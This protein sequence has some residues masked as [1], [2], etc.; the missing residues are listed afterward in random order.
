M[1]LQVADKHGTRSMAGD[2]P[3]AEPQGMSQARVAAY[4]HDN[5]IARI[6]ARGEHRSAG[7]GSNGQAEADLGDLEAHMAAQQPPAGQGAV[8]Q[9]ES[10]LLKIGS[11]FD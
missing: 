6:H 2:I 1:I 5:V 9:A 3:P 8:A 7:I 4:S 10:L 11:Q